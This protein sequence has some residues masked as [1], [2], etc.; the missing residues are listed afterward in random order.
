MLKKT[1]E[2]T[3]I[4]EGYSIHIT[5]ISTKP[6]G[7]TVVYLHGMCMYGAFYHDMVELFPDDFANFY[8][9]DLPNHG[10]SSGKKGH[11]PNA[12]T[13]LNCLDFTISTI[14]KEDQLDQI[15]LISAESMGGIVA[16]YYLLKRDP[17]KTN[18]YLIFGAPIY[19]NWSYFM[20][21]LKQ[22]QSTFWAMFARNKMVLPVKALLGDMTRN[23]DVYKQI[24]NDG[25]VPE[26]ANFNY[27]MPIYQMSRVLTAS[28][29]S[30]SK[31]IL[32]FY[33]EKDAICNL[34]KIKK[35]IRPMK[36]IQAI[37][38]PDEFHSICWADPENYKGSIREWLSEGL[39]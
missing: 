11:L 17:E 28:F 29:G 23:S 12:N 24:Q 3:L 32:L 18:K 30:I 27:L 13:I 34:K 10:R 4:F 25:L 2:R 39:K 1:T 20:T 7:K 8:F 19:L 16:L 36:N 31:D 26:N 33:G 38:I 5:K 22:P 6:A 15:D 35:L 14:K 9:I 37:V 21:D